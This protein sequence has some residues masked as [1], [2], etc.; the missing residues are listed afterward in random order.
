M[1]RIRSIKPEFWTDE[2]LGECSPTSRLLFIATWNVADDYGN[3][4]RSAKQIKA[5]AFP[6]DNIE[7][8]PLLQELLSRSRLTEYEA[9]GKKYLHINGFEKHQ[10]IEK[11]SKPRHPLYDESR[12]APRVVGE[13]KQTSNG[14]SLGEGREGIIAEA[15]KRTRK[16][17]GK[18]PIPDDFSLTDELRA[19]AAL[20]LQ[21]VD[22]DALYE[23]F[24]GNALAKGWEYANWAQA[25]QAFIRNCAPNSGHWAAGNYP[26]VP[27]AGQWM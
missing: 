25:L 17:K 7:C 5:Q 23:S 27:G 11:K 15:G 21:H 4:E 19:Y 3:L 6:Y 8:E 26:K 12:R 10:K 16:A 20:H 18:T 24:R 22:A 1:A 14:S 9:D 13:D 2:T